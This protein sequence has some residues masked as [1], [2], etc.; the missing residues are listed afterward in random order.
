MTKKKTAGD[1][2]TDLMNRLAA[3]LGDLAGVRKIAQI[4]VEAEDAVIERL[5]KLARE[6]D[7]DE[8]LITKALN[9]KKKTDKILS[10]VAVMYPFIPNPAILRA[11][12]GKRD[13]AKAT[14]AD[15]PKAL[16]RG[17]GSR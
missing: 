11:I 7:V 17:K 3:L 2:V 14:K 8:R 15:A 1:D 12:A 10:V 6:H 9:A 5:T 16:P 13:D 4:A